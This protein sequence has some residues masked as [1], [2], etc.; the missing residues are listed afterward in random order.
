MS[1]KCTFLRLFLLIISILLISSQNK[2]QAQQGHIIPT[3]TQQGKFTKAYK[4]VL[5][6]SDEH[7][8]ST[9]TSMDKVLFPDYGEHSIYW[10]GG[11]EQQGNFVFPDEIPQEF[12]YVKSTVYQNYNWQNN[13]HFSINFQK[14]QKKVAI[15]KSAFK[16]DSI[17]ISW[18]ALQFIKLFESY[19]P[20]DIFYLVDE[21]ELANE[22]LSDSTELLIIPSFTVK[23]E[24]YTYY[25]DSIVGLGYDFKSKLDAFLSGGGMIYTEGNAASFLEKTAYLE[26]GTIDYTNY[27]SPE[28]DLFKCQAADPDHPVSFSMDPTASMVYGNRIPLVN[29]SNVTSL[30]TLEEDSRPV[31]FNLEGTDANGGTLLCNLGLPVVK[32]LA[33]RG[34]PPVAMHP[35]CHHECFCQASGYHPCGQE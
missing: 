2:A 23:G 4:L 20:E 27:K 8:R 31:V 11:G 33:D 6:A 17:S 25:I 28:N 34:G 12:Q 24:D 3:G 16:A 21:E 35:E 19:L 30:V 9:G 32:G 5:Q 14:Q 13:P 18:Q 10:I 29:A 7:Y 22:G 15:F 26:S 1:I